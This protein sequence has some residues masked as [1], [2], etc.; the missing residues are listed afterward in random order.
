MTFQVLGPWAQAIPRYSQTQCRMKDGAEVMPQTIPLAY[1]HH[2]I[3]SLSL[4]W[5]QLV[6]NC[7]RHT[8]SLPVVLAGHL[9]RHHHRRALD[10]QGRQMV[11]LRRRGVRKLETTTSRRSSFLRHWAWMDWRCSR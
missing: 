2:H 9:Q 5:R 6:R 8:S 7:T 1:R 4:C 10:L 11:E 3:Y